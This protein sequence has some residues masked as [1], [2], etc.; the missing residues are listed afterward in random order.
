MPSKGLRWPG[1]FMDAINIFMLTKH[2]DELLIPG[3]AVL[4]RKNCEV[5]PHN[6]AL[7]SHTR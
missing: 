4:R 2:R 1:E 6:P 5:Q 3:R 7:L